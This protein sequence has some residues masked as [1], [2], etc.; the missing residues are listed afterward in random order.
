LT[1]RRGLVRQAALRIHPG[2]SFPRDTSIAL[3]DG[4]NNPGN[5]LKTS[6]PMPIQ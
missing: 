1:E 6:D 5:A 3:A 2:P 4:S